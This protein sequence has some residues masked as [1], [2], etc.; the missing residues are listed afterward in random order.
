MAYVSA[1]GNTVRV[2]NA[3]A[4][5]TGGDLFELTPVEPYT[6]ADLNWTD[7]D[8]RVVYEYENPEAR[9]MAL[10]QETPAGWDDYDVVFLGYPIWW[11]I[12]A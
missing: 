10:A 8:S 4:E 3:I 1:T 5:A 11:G 12:A 2:A 9:D 6:D 7:E